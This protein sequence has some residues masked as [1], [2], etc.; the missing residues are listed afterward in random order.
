MWNG[1]DK[2]PESGRRIIALFDDGSGARLFLAHDGGLLDL[3]GDEATLEEGYGLWAYLPD[4]MKL[5]FEQSPE[6]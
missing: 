6:R 5:W 4:G 3:D 1:L 2:K